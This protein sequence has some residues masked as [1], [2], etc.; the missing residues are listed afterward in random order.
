MR[1]RWRVFRRRDFGRRAAARC[2]RQA[3]RPRPPR[4]PRRRRLR[5]RAVFESPDA[6]SS[7]PAPAS[8]ACGCSIGAGAAAEKAVPRSPVLIRPIVLRRPWTSWPRLARGPG[9]RPVLNDAFKRARAPLV[10][11]HAARQRFEPHLEIP[12]LDADPRQ[13]EHEVVDELVVEDVDFVA[14]LAL[15]AER[16]NCCS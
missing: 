14:L 9:A 12:I 10:E 11:V 8:A 5:R 15:V 13:L 6:W 3:S 1:R 2:L 16:W 7:V 4:R